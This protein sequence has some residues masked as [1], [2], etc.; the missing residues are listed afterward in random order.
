[1][2][3]GPLTGAG[4]AHGPFVVPLLACAVPALALLAYALPALSRASA[5]RLGAYGP[6][7][8]DPAPTPPP[9]RAPDR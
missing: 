3:A 4:G 9:R 8:P 2:L 5:H 6:P 7:S 1:A